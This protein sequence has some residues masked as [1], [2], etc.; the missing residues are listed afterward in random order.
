MGTYNIK[1][2]ERLKSLFSRP[3]R[4]YLVLFYNPNDFLTANTFSSAAAFTAS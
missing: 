3:H 2:E 4:F 1:K